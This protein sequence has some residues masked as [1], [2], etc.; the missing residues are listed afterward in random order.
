MVKKVFN[1]SM[2]DLFFQEFP[3]CMFLPDRSNDSDWKERLKN[4]EIHI[5]DT[6]QK[7]NIK[8]IIIMGGAAVL[9]Y[10]QNKAK[11]Y[12][13]LIREIEFQD[14]K[15]PCLVLRSPEG[16]LQL[17]NKRKSLETKKDSREF[18][19]AREEENQ[20]KI[21]VVENLTKLKETLEI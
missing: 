19:D 10:G 9:Y 5:V 4:C 20:V 13:G 16:I 15:L 21:S 2:E 8:A 11:E 17:E 7:Y 6:I 18:K 1:F 3:A 14:I 12:N